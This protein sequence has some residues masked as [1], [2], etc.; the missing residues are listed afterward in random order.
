MSVLGTGSAVI[1]RRAPD[2]SARTATS[3]WVCSMIG[4]R[5]HYSLPRALE[6]QGLLGRFYTDAWAGPVLRRLQWGPHVWRSFAA[7]FHPSLASQKVSAFTGSQIR[8]QLAR[9]PA[10][11]LEEQYLR[12]RDDGRAFAW[13]VNQHLVR[14]WQRLQ[15][16]GLLG[17][18]TGCLETQQLFEAR[19]LPTIVDQIDPA[20]TE[21]EIVHAEAA[22]WPEWQSLPGRIPGAY[23][24]RLQAEWQLAARVIVNSE[25]S[26]DALVRQGVPREK[27]AILPLCYEPP[28]KP[29]PRR[30]V[31]SERELT[32]LWLGQVILRKGIQYLLAAARMLLQAPVQFVIA[33]PIGISQAAVAAAPK[34]VRFVGLVSRDRIADLYSTAD[35]FVLPTLSDGFAI[36]QLEAMSH[37][38]PVVTTPNCGRV[39]SDG[40]DGRIVKAGEAIELA[41]A[42]DELAIRRD[43][44]AEMSRKTADTIRRFSLPVMAERLSAI[45]LST[46]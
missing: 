17:Y 36:T 12:F 14:N 2:S 40:L 20:R 19:G 37:G 44:L 18:N 29:Q 27:I 30:Q 46:K 23:F 6:L 9:R 43:R 10:R 41:T 11:S 22:K 7:R 24:E 26:R 39:V 28:L 3:P 15:P 45:L 35:L 1:E 34:N 13:Q 33:G 38:L 5:E 16:G 32:V 4:A 42:I 8:Q 31:G 21:E 25:W